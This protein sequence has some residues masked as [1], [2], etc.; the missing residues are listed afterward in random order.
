ML[1]MKVTLSSKR[2][3]SIIDI[4]KATQEELIKI[5]GIGCDFITYFKAKRKSWRLYVY[6][7]DE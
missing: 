4:N 1:S 6:G 5:Y 3:I 2:K 7:A